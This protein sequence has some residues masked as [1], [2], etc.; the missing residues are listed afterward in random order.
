MLFTEKKWGRARL[1]VVYEDGL[2]Q[3]I[4]YKVIKSETNVVADFGNFLTTAQWF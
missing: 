3:T 4:N 2:Q 1:T